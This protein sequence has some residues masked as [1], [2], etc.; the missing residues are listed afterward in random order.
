[1]KKIYTPTGQQM[2]EAELDRQRQKREDI[3]FWIY[4]S[5]FVLAPVILFIVAIIWFIRTANEDP[6]GVLVFIALVAG[7][8][9]V[10]KL[11]K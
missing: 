5:I 10:E 7:L 2:I 4:A 3:K 1:M 8:A 11:K 9:M 6:V